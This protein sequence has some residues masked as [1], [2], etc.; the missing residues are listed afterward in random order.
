M[1][2][3]QSNRETQVLDELFQKELIEKL[4]EL[5]K[6]NL[7]CDIT[8]RAD[9]Q[10]FAAHR[11][12]LSA[13]SQYFRALFTT[14]LNVQENE[15]HFVELKEITSHALTEVLQ[16]VYTGKAKL[17]SSNAKEIVVASDYLMIEGLKSR[18][19]LFLEESLSV[20]NCLALESFA[21]RYN[22]ESLKQAATSFIR[23]N[24]ADVAKSSDFLSLNEEKLV[25]LLSDDEINIL[26]EEE[27]YN[28]A[29][30]WVKDDLASRESSLPELLKCLRLFS[31]SKFSL[32][33]ILDEE[34]LV[35]RDVLCM[36]LVLNGL[37]YFL[38]PDRFQNLSFKPRLSLRDDAD[39]VILTGGMKTNGMTSDSTC[40]FVLSTKKWI[41][42]LARM[43]Q[44]C[45]HH[46]VAMCRGN[47]YVIDG[48]RCFNEVSV[49]SFNPKKIEWYQTHHDIGRLGTWKNSSVTTYNEELYVIGGDS[50]FYQDVKVFNPAL[51]TWKGRA[52]MNVGRA[53]HCAVVLQNYI[54]V[55]GGHNG[56]VCHK[57]VERYD[58]STNRWQKIPNLSNARRS[59]AG[60]VSNGK[61]IVV[62]GFSAMEPSKAVEASCEVFD[63]NTN[64][65]SLVTSPVIPRAACGIVSIDDIIYLFG[66]QHEEHFMKT[67]ESFDLKRNEWRDVATMPIDRQCS[68]HQASFLRLPKHFVS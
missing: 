2:V 60:A 57:S 3:A 47:L 28:A 50:G 14:Q 15:V 17:N 38:F 33:Q 67:V 27:V 8:L 25:E 56:E 51:G 30:R 24:F 19:S 66:G 59:A 7:L 45:S 10:D 29:L 16:Y 1:A 53:G 40:C 18:A 48:K 58:P 12:V 20:A 5:R 68:F 43:P 63:P 23:K 6:S 37:D 31:M 62:G 26:R 52:P 42:S 65:W 54:Y 55:M 64:E 21:S 36:T 49:C 44:A 4:D 46:G 9:G 13:G 11:S 41:N 35:K 22:C 61:I 34:E 32:R 39:V